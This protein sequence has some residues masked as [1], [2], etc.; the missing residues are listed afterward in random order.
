MAR[1]AMINARTERELKNEVEEIL[2][3]L[4][5]STTEAIN[6]FFRQVKLRRGLP[7]PV[8]IPNDKT[9]KVFQDSEESKGLVECSDADDMFNRL[10]V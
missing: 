7:F 3:S 4:G 9:L 8:E 5:M 2:Q 10:G 1:T 6:I